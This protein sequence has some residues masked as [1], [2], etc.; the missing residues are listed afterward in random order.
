MQ[1]DV[2]LFGPYADAVGARSI[3]V[4]VP[5]RATVADVL[6]SLDAV[7]ALA[8]LMSGAHLAVNASYVPRETRVD[9][10]DELALIGLVGGG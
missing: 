1:A 6:A 9:A 7:P 4:E 3:A 2:L 10:T 8:P 5:P